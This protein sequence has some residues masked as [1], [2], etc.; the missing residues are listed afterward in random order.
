[1]NCERFQAVLDDFLNG[2]LSDESPAQNHLE[3]CAGCRD[4]VALLREDLELPQVPAPAGLA[5]A[6]LQ[7]TSGPACKSAREFLPG[8]ADG[9]LP[10]SDTELLAIHIQGC[11]DC[12][13]LEAAVRMLAVDLPNLAEMEPP[14][15]FT[16]QVLAAT[17]EKLSLAQRFTASVQT[18]MQRPRFAFEAAYIASI[19]LVLLFGLPF[20]GDGG[21]RVLEMAR[22]QPVQTLFS[23]DGPVAGAVH[24]T[25]AYAEELGGNTTRKAKEKVV[26]RAEG[27]TGWLRDYRDGL[28]QRWTTEDPAPDQ[29]ENGNATEE[30][31]P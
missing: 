2:N 3:D 13:S 28:K 11:R 30:T 16:A 29:P 12:R 21:G 6:V 7:R 1:M 4:L 31:E 15:G 23:D 22:M 10:E 19:T 27:V 17:S 25:V 24:Q 18:M 5:E 20:T 26:D 14:A 8:Y 9:G